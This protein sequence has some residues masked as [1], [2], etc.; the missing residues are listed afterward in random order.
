MNHGPNPQNPNS[1]SPATNDVLVFIAHS[2]EPCPHCGRRVETGTFIAHKN[3]A[4]ACT[5]CAGLEGLEF[6]PSGNTALTRRASALTGKKFVVLQFSRARKR[7]E[8]QGI[9]VRSDIID[10]ARRECEADVAA[11]EIKRLASAL[12]REK[13]DAA[14]LGAFAARIRELY[15][16]APPGMENEIAVHACRKHSG[17]V[18]RSAFAKDL[19]PEAI[20][21]AVR[22]H[23]RHSHTSY[24]RLVSGGVDRSEARLAVGARIEETARRW[25]S[26]GGG[27][28]Q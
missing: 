21:L 1:A 18:G 27:H 8:R 12:R 22:A 24:D 3:D 2:N 17:R 26:A 9:L 4:I 14:H 28:S 16:S 15:P 6:L 13:K 20:H 19:E 5:R 10:Q 11:R 25:R 7:Y 23:I